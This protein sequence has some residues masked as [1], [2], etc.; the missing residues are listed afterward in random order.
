[1]NNQKTPERKE[2]KKMIDHPFFGMLRGDTQKS[3][4]DILNELRELRYSNFSQW[5]QYKTR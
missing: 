5:N 1:M 4:L 3:T 2:T